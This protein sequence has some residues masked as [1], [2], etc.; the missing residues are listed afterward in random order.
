MNS[1]TKDPDKKH[2]WK[3]KVPPKIK[4]FMWFLENNTLL[5]KDNIV[6]RK[7]FV[8]PSCCLCTHNETIEHLFFTCPIARMIWGNVVKCLDTLLIPNNMESC[9]SWL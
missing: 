5:T 9:Y 3:S 6:R 7:W 8:D 1:A 2:I 4:F